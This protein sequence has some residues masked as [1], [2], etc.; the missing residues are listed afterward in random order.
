MYVELTVVE[1]E[2]KRWN[3]L[4]GYCSNPTENYGD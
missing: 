1:Q 4:G 2:L 3:Q